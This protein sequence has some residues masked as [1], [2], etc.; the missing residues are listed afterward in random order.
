MST[1]FNWTKCAN[2]DQLKVYVYPSN[3][4][5]LVSPVYEKILKVLRESYLYTNDPNS[6][7]LFFL[8][9]DTIDRDKLRFYILY[10]FCSIEFF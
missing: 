9:I 8:S 7:C 6:A 4:T 3:P 2:A 1:C 10:S 5:A